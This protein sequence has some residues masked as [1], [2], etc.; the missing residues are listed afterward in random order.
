MKNLLL[1]LILSVA[2]Q[3]FALDKIL[4]NQLLTTATQ[5]VLETQQLIDEVGR[6]KIADV[7]FQK[8]Q[9]SY[10]ALAQLKAEPVEEKTQQK[11]INSVFSSLHA[12]LY[13]QQQLQKS[14]A[15]TGSGVIRGTVINSPNSQ[16]PLWGFVRLFDSSGNYRGYSDIDSVGRYMFVNLSPNQYLIVAYLHNSTFVD[17][18]YPQI[19]CDGG[20][21]Y[22][23][24][25]SDLTPLSLGVDEIL[26]GVD[27]QITIK[28][29]IS[30]VVTDEANSSLVIHY[31]YVKLYNSSGMQVSY[32]NGGYD[33]SY[34]MS[35]PAPG[36]Y[37]LVASHSNYQTELY[38]NVV[39]GMSNCDFSLGTLIHFN[40]DEQK[41]NFNITLEKAPVIS[42]RIYD[43]VTSN[44]LVHSSIRIYDSN[45]SV[46][47]SSNDLSSD[48]WEFGLP[49]GNYTAAVSHVGYLANQYSNINCGTV[50]FESCQSVSGLVF[51]HGLSGTTGIDF[52]LEKGGVITGKVTNTLGEVLS[53]VSINVFSAS[54]NQ[55][56][57]DTY[58]DNNGMYQTSALNNGSYYVVANSAYDSIYEKQ[59]YNNIYCENNASCDFNFAT[60]IIVNNLTDVNNIDFQLI[61]NSEVSGQVVD[62]NNN[63]LF[64]IQIVAVS[65]DA[66]SN[67]AR[68]VFTDSD[69]NYLLDK[70]PRGNYRLYA[71]GGEYYQSESYNNFPCS[72]NDCSGASYTNLILNDSELINRNFQLGNKPTV[73]FNLTSNSSNTVNSGSIL[74]YRA[75]G[76]YMTYGE[77]DK[78]FGLPTGDY[79][80]VYQ[81]NGF[82]SKFVSKVYG[83]ANCFN[84]CDAVSGSL[85]HVSANSQQTLNMFIDEKFALHFTTTNDYFDMKVYDS[86]LSS[87]YSSRLNGSSVQYFSDLSSKYLKFFKFGYY[88]QLYSGINCEDSSCDIL[89]GQLV[90]PQLNSSL[91]INVALTPLASISGRIQDENNNPL[92]DKIVYLLD[93]QNGGYNDHQVTTGSNGE[94][95]FPV[96]P[97]GSYY[98]FVKNGDSYNFIDSHATTY[99]GDV[100][101]EDQDCSSVGITPISINVGD[102]L[103]GYDIHMV[104]RGTLSGSGIVNTFNEIKD[105]RLSLYKNEGGGLYN[106]RNVELNDSTLP[107]IY[108]PAGEYKLVIN[109]LINNQSQN[110]YSAFPDLDC[111]VSGLLCASNAVSV[112]VTNGNNTNFNS[113]IYHEQGIIKGTVN[114]ADTLQPIQNIELKSY[115]EGQGLSVSAQTNTDALGYYELLIP[116]EGPFYLYFDTNYGYTGENKNY[117]SQLYNSMDCMRGIGLGCQLNQGQ[118]VPVMH[119]TKTVIN[120]VLTP[121]PK[122]R[123]NFVDSISR[124]AIQHGGIY[125]FDQS[126]NEVSIQNYNSTNLFESLYPGSYYIIAKHDSQSFHETRGYPNVYCLDAAQPLSCISPMQLI[127]LNIGDPTNVI[128]LESPLLKGISGYVKDIDTGQPIVDVIVD[129]WNE[130]GNVRNMPV[131]TGINGGFSIPTGDN[132]QSYLSTDTNSAYINEVY[133]DIECQQPAILGGCDVTQGMLVEVPQNNLTPIIVN[134]ELSTNSNQL[135]KNGFE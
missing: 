129:S 39:C 17:T 42:G 11:E 20:L 70:L 128:T 113:F 79:Y 78:V 32:S 26:Q 41:Q 18:A 45:G 111:R 25:I 61:K 99:Y 38:D 82:N 130:N 101:C 80:F 125:I 23:C 6:D 88:S 97:E 24:Q 107:T 122:L 104:T 54:T 117:I 68:S 52:P 95:D 126:N 76:S 5:Q 96:L 9:E 62:S 114:D 75:D 4:E 19:P 84:N 55:L 65:V 112:L 92:A 132:M 48:L 108:L 63:P 116:N 93:T 135:F 119:D 47:S 100:A 89:Q 120:V 31:P 59:L 66:N 34:S 13:P 109:P 27:I 28:P 131:T 86:D 44:N 43:E 40:S 29:R 12:I 46:V 37:F 72:T 56:L 35:L 10:A 8:L 124:E 7:Y 36:D 50:Y 51:N 1:L 77:Y 94:Y 22:G 121:K 98:L 83:G 102:Y 15:G 49:I 69:G 134:I 85:V 123:V 71:R 30:G 16:N 103:N 133:K 91:T 106:I 74:V 67:Y 2:N 60:A 105:T 53:Y 3:T 81:G 21:G 115:L 14:V 90:I 118:L 33:G 57:Y 110:V 87:S 58:T 64:G 73:S 127:T